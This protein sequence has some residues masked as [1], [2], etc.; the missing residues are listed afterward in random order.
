ME[1][2]WKY[3]QLSFWFPTQIRSIKYPKPTSICY[4][5][6]ATLRKNCLT[7]TLGC[8]G[9]GGKTAAAGEG[10]AEPAQGMS[11]GG[12]KKN[13]RRKELSR[14]FLE[15]PKCNQGLKLNYRSVIH[16]TSESSM[17][18]VKWS[19]FDEIFASAVSDRPS[20]QRFKKS[21]FSQLR[22]LF[23]YYSF[24]SFFGVTINQSVGLCNGKRMTLTQL[25]SKY[26]EAQIVIGTHVG[27][28]VCIPRIIMT[29]NDTKWPF[30]LRRRQ[31]YCLFVL[32]WQSTR[33]K[34]IY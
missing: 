22:N 7:C 30:K 16:P 25:G 31:F 24:F 19:H 32:Q 21:N 11:G 8:C 4:C 6:T 28:K 26:I 23:L 10:R 18:I 2:Y 1:R 29:S 12:R 17:W 27:D 14:L 15:K 33:V 20:K 5:S 9:R 34:H 13:D 3:L